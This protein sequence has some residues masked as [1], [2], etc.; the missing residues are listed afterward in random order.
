M[1]P[2][3]QGGHRLVSEN[4]MRNTLLLQTDIMFSDLSDQFLQHQTW[5]KRLCNAG[6]C[7]R[8]QRQLPT[9]PDQTNTSK[10]L[11][12]KNE[13][14]SYKRYFPRILGAITDLYL[15]F[16]YLLPLLWHGM[17]FAENGSVNAWKELTDALNANKA[18][19]S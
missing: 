6:Y 3:D 18:E 16:L 8:W 11:E 9:E 4:L 5:N 12:A 15:S 13:L 7:K 10:K 14:N 1:S 19:R 17:V 2:I